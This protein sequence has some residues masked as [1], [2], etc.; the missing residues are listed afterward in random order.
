MCSRQTATA[1]PSIVFR[2]NYGGTLSTN[3]QLTGST[4]I[5]KQSK[6]LTLR[7]RFRSNGSDDFFSFFGSFESFLLLLHSQNDYFFRRF[8]RKSGY[9]I[10]F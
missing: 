4:R 3:T 7:L 10:V 6:C 1:F 2:V 9:F 5:N 8:D